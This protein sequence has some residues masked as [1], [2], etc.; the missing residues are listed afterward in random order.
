VNRV[1]AIYKSLPRAGQWLVW[2]LV[3]VAA[4]FGLVE[5]VMDQTSSIGSKADAAASALVSYESGRTT[6]DREAGEISRGLRQFGPVLLP[7]EAGERSGA[8]NRRI[9]EILDKQG[10]K[11]PTSTTRT[12]PLT[13][14]PLDKTMPAGQRVERLIRDLQFDATPEQVTA[15]LAALE[16]SP[17]VAA[18]SRVQ[19]RRAAGGAGSRT[20]RANITVEGLIIARKDHA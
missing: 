12:A 14:G 16:R 19:I 2:G 18:V 13:S 11:Y 4:Y 15:V 20:V 9:T 10:V 6:Q 1:T 8:F 17:E 5:P 7:G 3:C